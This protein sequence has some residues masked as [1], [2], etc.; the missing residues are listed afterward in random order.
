MDK[1]SKS[2]GLTNPMDKEK[3]V[4]LVTFQYRDITNKLLQYGIV[5]TTT[6][7]T[8]NYFPH[9]LSRVE[10]GLQFIKI[11]NEI[12]QLKDGDTERY[13]DIHNSKT[14]ERLFP[15]YAY[16]QHM[17]CGDMRNMSVY[18]IYSLSSHFMGAMGFSRRDIIELDVPESAIILTRNAGDYVECVLPCIKKEWIV[19]ILKFSKWV[20]EAYHGENALLYNNFVYKEDTYRMCYSNNIVFNGHGKGDCLECALSSTMLDDITDISIQRD[21]VQTN[22]FNTFARYMSMIRYTLTID[23]LIDINGRNAR[24]ELSDVIDLKYI[25]SFSTVSSKLM[26]V[27]GKK[28]FDNDLSYKERMKIVNMSVDEDFDEDID[29]YD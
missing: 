16:K 26:E 8:S 21:Y 23:D 28:V 13:Y 17:F 29:E 20:T 9:G 3:Y 11:D 18:T 27:L 10:N 15:F 12:V 6:P 1:L 2:I 22:V 25:K 14:K 7:F 19:S 4:R 24:A 5:Q